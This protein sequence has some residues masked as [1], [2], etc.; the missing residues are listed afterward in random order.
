M[1]DSLI[2]HLQ[3]IMRDTGALFNMK[4]VRGLTD[5]HVWTD[6]L[7]SKVQ[8]DL[9]IESVWIARKH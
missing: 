4:R 8:Q 6:A 5:L 9:V 7:V 3:A 1:H 2:Y